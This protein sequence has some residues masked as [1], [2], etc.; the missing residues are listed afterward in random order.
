MRLR[1]SVYTQST[2]FIP[3]QTLSL[4]KPPESLIREAREHY[5]PVM[6][7]YLDTY[8]GTLPRF[9]RPA[10]SCPFGSPNRNS[11]IEQAIHAR[12][13]LFRHGRVRDYGKVIAMLE[14]RGKLLRSWRLVWSCS[15]VGGSRID[16]HVLELWTF[17]RFLLPEEP[18]IV[19]G[20][21]GS[22]GWRMGWK[23]RREASGNSLIF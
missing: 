19:F 18:T 14:D 11:S 23:L 13:A 3:G 21:L 9:T 16:R 12:S 2:L 7:Q 8:D 20:A 15:E 1:S 22:A 6:G 10:P 4:L 17:P 5:D